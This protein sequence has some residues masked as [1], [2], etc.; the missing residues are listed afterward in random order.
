M[1][2]I[3]PEGMLAIT[4]WL[5]VP[6]RD[7]LKLFATVTEA[8]KRA[9]AADP[10]QSIA[11]IRSWNT[12]TMLVKNGDFSAR[13]I[14]T[15]KEFCKSNSF[16]TAFYPSMNASEANRYNLLD[17]PFLFNGATALAGQGAADFFERYKFQIERAT[18][19]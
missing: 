11:L 2:H 1:Q 3:A 10:A 6:P 16:D 15:I 14:A 4:R 7:S 19:D 5:K 9:G 17:Q 8:L 12:S 13:E 18:D